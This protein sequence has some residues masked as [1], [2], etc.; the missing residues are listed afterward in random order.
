MKNIKI[1]PLTLIVLLTL[2]L[3]FAALNDITTGT[4]PFKWEE[5]DFLLL[6]L[7]FFGLLIYSRSNKKAS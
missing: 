1:T 2:L 6:S 7:I 3:D 4:E 5:W